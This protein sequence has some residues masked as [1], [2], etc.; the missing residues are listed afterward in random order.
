MEI[1]RVSAKKA[2]AV[3]WEAVHTVHEQR[4][5]RVSNIHVANITAVDATV[6]VALCASGES[7]SASVALLYQFT[8]GG[9]EF[10]EFGEGLLVTP[11]G[12]IWAAAGALTSINIFVNGEES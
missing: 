5:F 9:N 3:A 2:L 10:L 8:L 7:P 1:V 12:S 6:S 4:W 11:S